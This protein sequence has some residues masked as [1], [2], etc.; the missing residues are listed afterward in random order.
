MA[1]V[2]R[3]SGPEGHAMAALPANLTLEPPNGL[4]LAIVASSAMPM[5]LLDGA[6]R[7]IASVL[8]QTA[9]RVQ[10]EETRGYLHDAHHRIMSVA[11]MQRQLAVTRQG[12]V[13]LGPYLTE[14]C[15][16]IGASMIRD[17][18]KVVL[19]VEIENASIA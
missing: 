19:N 8:M 7:I 2:S 16:S 1:F 15:A 18:K 4:A 6:L 17:H 14:L 10:S 5:L 9:R 3:A 13:E 12:S 11:S